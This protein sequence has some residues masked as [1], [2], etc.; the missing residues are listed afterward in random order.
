MKVYVRGWADLGPARGF[1][2]EGNVRSNISLTSPLSTRP[3]ICGVASGSAT[4][5]KYAG[6]GNEEEKKENPALVSVP[7]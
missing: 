2:W 6:G 7:N 1:L 5:P 3:L 4:Q